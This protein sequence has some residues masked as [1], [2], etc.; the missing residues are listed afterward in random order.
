MNVFSEMIFHWDN[1]PVHTARTVTD[2]LAGKSVKILEHPPYSPDL[3]PA[4]FW[5]FPK[6]KAALAGRFMDSGTFKT[7]W[8]GVTSLIGVQEY[9]AAFLKWAERHEKCSRLGNY[10]EKSQ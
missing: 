9:E 6:I 10:V 3:A 5:L 2:Y 8:D 7:E 4:D 1:A